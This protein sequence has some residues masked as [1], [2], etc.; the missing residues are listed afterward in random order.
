MDFYKNIETILD[1]LDLSEGVDEEGISELKKVAK[2]E[3]DHH[4]L[5]SNLYKIGL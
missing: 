4:T 1:T 2:K 5:A 3:V